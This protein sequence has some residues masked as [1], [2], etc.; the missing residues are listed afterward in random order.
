MVA[1]LG[2]GGQTLAVQLKHKLIVVIFAGNY[3]DSNH[4]KL[5]LKIMTRFV[6]PALQTKLKR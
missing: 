3:D 2:D 1:G 4:G 5:P 6:M